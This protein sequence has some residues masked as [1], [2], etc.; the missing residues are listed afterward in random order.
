M[1]YEIIKRLVDVVGAFF[2]LIL[3]SPIILL[4]ALLIKLTSDGPVF[5]E[6]TNSHM[7]RLGINGKKFRLYKFR[8]MI[9]K[10]D[11]LERTDPR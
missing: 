7:I 3:F 5:V 9:V 2:L 10:A 4:T 11:V 8:S 6:K 1:Y